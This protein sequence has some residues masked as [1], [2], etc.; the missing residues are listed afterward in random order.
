MTNIADMNKRCHESGCTTRS[1]FGYESDMKKV[2]CSKH[3]LSGMVDL[4][5][6]NKRCQEVGCTIQSCF[7]FKTDM[8]RVRCSKHQLE[9]MI[10]LKSINTLCQEDGCE[11]RANFGKLFEKKIHCAVHKQPNEFFKNNP[12]CEGDGCKNRPLFGIEKVNTIP[13]RCEKHRISKDISMISRECES[14]LLDVFIPSTQTKCS[15]C[16][17]WEKL[18]KTIEVLKKVK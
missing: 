1:S 5:N 12:K 3:K 17:G 18:I 16:L 7:G 15:R 9:G 2:R 4:K 11:T 6:M 10:N 14:C 13:I 8:E